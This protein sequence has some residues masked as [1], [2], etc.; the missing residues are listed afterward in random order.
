M[1]KK[2]KDGPFKNEISYNLGYDPEIIVQY[3]EEGTYK[4]GL[5]DGKYEKYNFHID[6]N[7]GSKKDIMER[8]YFS[9]GKLHGE[10]EKNC[11]DLN[12]YFIGEE[13]KNLS[14]IY[15]MGILVEEH[16]K[17]YVDC[18]NHLHKKFYKKGKIFKEEIFND[19]MEDN[20][21]SS[22]QTNFFDSNGTIIDTKNISHYMEEEDPLD[23]ISL[24]SVLD[25]EL[26]PHDSTT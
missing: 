1:S 16:Y 4:N 9:M 24:E 23:S 12:S 13:S 10:Y 26:T 15:K 2:I 21:M 19:I 25:S 11:F 8:M 20:I 6:R 5:L 17:S 7:D 18:K 14:C 3:F 22:F